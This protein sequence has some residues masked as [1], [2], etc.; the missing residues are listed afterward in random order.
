MKVIALSTLGI[1]VLLIVIV[2]KFVGLG[3]KVETLEHRASDLALK[4]KIISGMFGSPLYNFFASDEFWENTYDS[5]HADCA[6]RCS[7]NLVAEN[8]ICLAMADGPDKTRCFEEALA[9]AN[10]CQVQCSNNHQTPTIP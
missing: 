10:N 8:K 3:A 9:R 6:G 2:K 7:S 5:G 4:G 1:G